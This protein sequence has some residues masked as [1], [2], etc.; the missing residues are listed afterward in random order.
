MS[1]TVNPDVAPGQ[2]WLSFHIGEQLYAAP[3]AEVSE[4]IRI[5]ELTP[6]PG[7]AAD[8]LGVRHLRGRIVPVL[9][10]RMRLGLPALPALD[11]EHAR[12]VMLAHEAHLIG[13]R[14]DSVGELLNTEGREI[15]PPPPGRANRV[16]DPV[17]GVL[18]WQ[19]GFVA[20]L[21]VRRLCRLNQ[22]RPSDA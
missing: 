7:V 20:L 22:G 15:A 19:G 16:D 2:Q 12:V 6:V 1:S 10:G 14:V 17:S 11:P 13:L 18:A 21:D 9:D 5:G 4:V 3:L 8:V